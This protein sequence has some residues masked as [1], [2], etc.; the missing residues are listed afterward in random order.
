MVE[1]LTMKIDLANLDYKD[2]HELLVGAIVPRPIVLVS[3]VGEDGVFNVAPFSFFT[4]LCV[5]PALIGF[6]IARR[7]GGQKKDTLRNIEFSKEFVVN[8]VTESMAKAINQAGEEYPSYVDEFKETGMRPEK[9]DIVKAP[10]VAE[11]PINMECRLVQI[12][13]FGE[14]PRSASFI[15]GEVVR[16]HVKDE[17]W[18]NGQIQISELR[19]IGRLG[20]ELCC[21]TMDTFA[22]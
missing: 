14:A 21:R 12:L 20:G 16:V 8:V 5:K 3:T 13:E 10:M 22:I 6:N 19:T 9:A 2:S 18:V 1:G 17:F 11:S 4:G 15:I 7:R